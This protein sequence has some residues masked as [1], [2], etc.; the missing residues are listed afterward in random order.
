MKD[1]FNQELAVGD[2]VLTSTPMGSGRGF[3]I[4]TVER[5]TPKKVVATRLKLKSSAYSNSS[6]FTCYPAELVKLD[7]RVVSMKILTD[8]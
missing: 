6:S 4:G 7:D 2:T 1:F 5:F 8:I 3:M